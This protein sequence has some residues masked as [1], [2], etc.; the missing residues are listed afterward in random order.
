MVIKKF[1][2]RTEEVAIST[3]KSE[4]GDNIVIMNVK[5]ATRNGLF[6]FFRNPK[7]EVTVAREDENEKQTIK[8]ASE[9]NI[10]ETFRQVAQLV[11]PDEV[12][13]E[14]HDSVTGS[15]AGD[16]NFEKKENIKDKIIE[17]KL[18]SLQ[19]LL[20]KKLKETEE[21][22]EINK[23]EQTKEGKGNEKTSEMLHFTQLLQNTMLDNE[24]EDQ[25]VSQI[26]EE[27]EQGIKTDISL[28]MALANVYQRMILKF[29]KAI[30]I[31]P[32]VSGP[33]VVFFVGPTGVGKTTT[34]A[35]LAS[36]FS[37]VE[38]KKVALLTAD[39]FRIA[40][41]EQLRT[42]AGILDIPFQIIYSVE[43]VE[44]ALQ[45]FSEMDYILVDTTGHS[46][47]NEAQK[48][49]VDGVIKSVDQK[50]EKEIHLVLSAT[51]K[52]RDLH[53]IADTYSEMMDYHIIFTKL[54]ETKAIGN[55]LN[56]KLYTGAS[57]SYITYGQNV[58]EDIEEFNP[59]KAV[60]LL[61]GGKN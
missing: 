2:G 22:H 28:D 33:K 23:P 36:Q 25:Y 47:L 3:A 1:V 41:A 57:L 30:P 46:Q 51:T 53:T 42:Y 4:L 43:D 59:Q 44:K 6:S 11:K 9:E 12:D 38:K 48:E 18:D 8:K 60:K 14:E 10:K 55:L 19:N 34:I 49:L 27:M 29:G 52:N 37:I 45:D 56:I 16:A 40:A 39:T 17:E 54:D 32:A 50:A 5:K 24:I 7:I 15:I 13:I 61:L 31:K 20:S 21:D 26:I 58:P 35:K